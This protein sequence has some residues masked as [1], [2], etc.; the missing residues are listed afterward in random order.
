MRK[1]ILGALF[2]ATLISPAQ[3]DDYDVCADLAHLADGVVEVRYNG[4]P[5]GEAMRVANGGAEELRHLFRAIV[6]DAY[7]LPD[8]T[9][10]EYQNRERRAYSNDLARSCYLNWE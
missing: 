9:T 5:I 10:P 8:F 7:A 3:A 6:L 2:G 4:V 1:A